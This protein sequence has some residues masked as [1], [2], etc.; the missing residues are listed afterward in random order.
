MEGEG[1]TSRR[2]HPCL[3]KGCDLVPRH[4]ITFLVLAELVLAQ[5][6]FVFRI[7]ASKLIIEAQDLVAERTRH[8][9]TPLRAFKA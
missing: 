2:F 6:L 7:A 1:F 5:N 4:S 9:F 3:V 8:N